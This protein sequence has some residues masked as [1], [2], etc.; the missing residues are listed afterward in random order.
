MQKNTFSTTDRFS[1]DGKALIKF[2][3][4]SMYPAS[5]PLTIY[6]NDV[7]FSASVASPYGYPGGGFNTGAIAMQII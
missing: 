1:P 2:G 3:L 6:Q 5:T 7:K 4:F